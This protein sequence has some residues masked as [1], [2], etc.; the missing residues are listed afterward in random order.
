MAWHRDNAPSGRVTLRKRAQG[1][2]NHRQPIVHEALTT[3]RSLLA[4][5][6][7]IVIQHAAMTMGFGVLSKPPCFM[8]L[9]GL[10]RGETMEWSH[11]WPSFART[12]NGHLVRRRRR[13]EASSKHH[14]DLHSVKRDLVHPRRRHIIASEL[15]GRSRPS[16]P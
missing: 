14:G 2:P 8:G 6:P 3:P 4:P 5:R 7:F 13:L 16:S 11:R 1:V 15:D 9:F 12:S 10:R